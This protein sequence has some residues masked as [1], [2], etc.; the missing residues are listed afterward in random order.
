MLR[1]LEN[2]S[3][4]GISALLTMTGRPLK[5]VPTGTQL[6]AGV[7]RQQIETDRRVTASAGGARIL[8]DR[9]EQLPTLA[10]ELHHLHLLVDAIVGRGRVGDHA[11]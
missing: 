4:T 1:R 7:R 6:P 3:E 10:V 2:A 9:A 8:D 5:F 11:G